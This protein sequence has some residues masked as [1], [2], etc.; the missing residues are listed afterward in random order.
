MSLP[1]DR[2]LH[3]SAISADHI[4]AMRRVLP[5]L[6]ALAVS[7]CGTTL[8]WDKPGASDEAISADLVT[9]RRAAQI[10]A[11]RYAYF[12]WGWGSGWGWGWGPR[13]SVF[14]QMRADDDRFVTE[15]RLTAFCMRTKGYEQVEVRPPQSQAP[16]P[17]TSPEPPTK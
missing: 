5:V 10:E 11:N 8:R 14:W 17:L 1:C 6:L 2:G 7:A 4:T 9:C 16:Q 13:R 12:P 3:I 15:N